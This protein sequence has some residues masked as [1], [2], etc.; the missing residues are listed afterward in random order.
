MLYGASDFTE[1]FAFMEEFM[2]I[3]NDFFYAIFSFGNYIL[4]GIFVFMGIMLFRNAREIE[5]G[6]KVPR[7]IDSLKKRAR[8]GSIS[9]FFIAFGFLSKIFIVFLYDIFLLL[10][11]PELVIRVIVGNFNKIN[12]LNMANSLPIYDRSLF[13]F[14]SFLSFASIILI[15]IS[16]YLIL[17]NKYILRY[18]V[19][20]STFLVIGL[21][22]WFF[23]GFRASLKL[24]I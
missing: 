23:F 24:L 14:I 11:E 5:H 12:S 7:K 16:T 20:I 22:L 13:F 8:A 3:I 2:I 18:K 6:E 19:K 9:C 17:F 4:F 10:P 1:I 21:I 15:A